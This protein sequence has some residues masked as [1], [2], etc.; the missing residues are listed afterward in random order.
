MGLPGSFVSIISALQNCE[1]RVRRLEKLV[2]ELRQY[3]G[4][5]HR[6]Q[7]AWAALKTVLKNE[8]IVELRGQLYEDM[9]ALQLSISINS[10]QLQCV[11]LESILHQ[12]AEL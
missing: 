8:E 5:N 6:I 12:C 10:A 11:S 9:V 4:R 1:K 3:F 7:K 2:S